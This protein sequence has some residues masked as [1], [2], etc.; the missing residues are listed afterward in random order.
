MRSTGS[1][2]I[3]SGYAASEEKDPLLFT[4][5]SAYNTALSP[6]RVSGSIHDL[7][8]RTALYNNIPQWIIDDDAKSGNELKKLLQI[9]GSYFDTIHSQIEHVKKFREAKYISSTTKLPI[10]F[11][12][13]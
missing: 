9:I 7:D 8:N 6:L 4:E 10:I 5:N 3:L 11:R 2:M 13:Y 1:A 12:H